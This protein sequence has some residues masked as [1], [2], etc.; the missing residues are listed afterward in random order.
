MYILNRKKFG[1]TY[2]TCF[3]LNLRSPGSPSMCGSPTKE[4][5]NKHSTV[6]TISFKF[7]NITDILLKVHRFVNFS[8][9]RTFSR[10][11]RCMKF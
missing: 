4:I 7:E 5:L 10:F 3:I 9:G 8:D 2:L 6:N 11:D 1:K